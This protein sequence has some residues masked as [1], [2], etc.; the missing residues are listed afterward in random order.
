MQ[1]LHKGG[2]EVAELE[3]WLWLSCNQWKKWLY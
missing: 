1:L 2:A 3:R